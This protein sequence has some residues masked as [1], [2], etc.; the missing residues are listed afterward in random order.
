[1]TSHSSSPMLTSTFLVSDEFAKNKFTY[2]TDTGGDSN[3]SYG[4]R[5]E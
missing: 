2:L 4:E 1:M 3:D 5:E